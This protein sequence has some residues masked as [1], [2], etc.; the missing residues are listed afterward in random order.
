MAKAIAKAVKSPNAVVDGEVSPHRPVRAGELLGAPARDRGARLLRV[1][2]ARARRRAADR[3]AAAASARTRCASC[4]TL[5]SRTSST[6]RASTT[7]TRCSRSPASGGS[8]AWSRSASTAS[9]RKGRRTRDW[10]KVKTEHNEEFVVAGYTR[11]GG[12]RAGTFGS[13]VLAVN[14]GGELRYVGNVGTGFDDA[15]IRKLLALLEP[16]RRDSA[17]VRGRAEVAA[18]SQGRRALGRAAAARAG[19]VR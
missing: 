11:G 8:K 2:P 13:L 1:R 12:R 9:T 5:A 10:L 14:E 15:E 4:S 7:A 3:A 16:L 18:G 19:A 17:A 6:R